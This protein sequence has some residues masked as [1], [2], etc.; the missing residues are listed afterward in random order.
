M[1]VFFRIIE[2]KKRGSNNARKR[3]ISVCERCIMRINFPEKI[4]K[5]LNC[6]VV[7]G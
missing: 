6:F 7:L 3:A 2:P 1:V 4:G 5:L